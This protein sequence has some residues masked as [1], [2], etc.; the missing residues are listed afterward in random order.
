MIGELIQFEKHRGF[1]KGQLYRQHPAPGGRA[2]DI[3]RMSTDALRAARITRLLM[4]LEELSRRS[5]NFPPT[6]LDQA[7]T[8][9]QKTRRIVRSWTATENDLEGAPQP[10]LDDERIERMYRELNKDV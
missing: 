3:G 10:E 4:E 5:G 9:L 6:T 7:R 8:D 2:P 1:K